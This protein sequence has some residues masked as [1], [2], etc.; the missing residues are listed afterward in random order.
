MRRLEFELGKIANCIVNDM[1]QI[2]KG[3]VVAITCDSESNMDVVESIAALIHVKK[4]KPVIMLTPQF[5]GYQYLVDIS[6]DPDF[7]IGALNNADVWI[8]ANS[9]DC[10]YSRFFETVMKENKRIRYVLIGCQDTRTMY[11]IFGKYDVFKMIELCA[12]LKELIESTKTVRMTNSKGT[13]V[14]F[15]ID[16]NYPV[17]DWGGDWTRPGFQLL[18]AGVNIIPEFNSTNGKIAF[19][20]VY[21]VTPNCVMK[22]PLTVTVKDGTIVGAEGNEYAD[23]FFEEMVGW[24]D[25]NAMKVSHVNFGLIPTIR[26]L[27]G[28]VTIDER[29]WGAVNWGFGYISPILAPPHGQES[30]YHIDCQAVKVSTWLD[31]VQIIDKGEFVHPELKK[32]YMELEKSMLE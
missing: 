7:F 6:I 9:K 22:S 12:K 24:N 19:D 28:Y 13:D 25:E 3:D 18:P 5:K 10:M 1:L 23:A 4:G 32:I 15:N 27:T 14:S 2:K 17:I 11:Q 29:V 31:G 20:A 16:P 21:E 8:D 30:D 26:E